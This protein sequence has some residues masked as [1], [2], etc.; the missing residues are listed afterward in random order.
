MTAE[1]REDFVAATQA[2]DRVLTAG[3]YAIPLWQP[4][5]SRLAYW[6]DLAHPEAIPVYGDWVGW[7]P[8]VWWREDG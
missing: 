1:T 7:L 3:R 4:A 6:S 2:L 8:H 5:D